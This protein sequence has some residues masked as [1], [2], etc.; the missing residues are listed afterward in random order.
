MYDIHSRADCRFAAPPTRF[1]AQAA[2]HTNVISAFRV[3]KIR[4]AATFAATD[5]TAEELMETCKEAFGDDP[6]EA[7]SRSQSWVDQ[8][9]QRMGWQ[10]E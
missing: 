7:W 3:Q 5:S 2:L 10:P 9:P 1:L 4:N 8:R 6:I